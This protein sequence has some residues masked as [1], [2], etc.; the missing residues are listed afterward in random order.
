MAKV[1][2]LQIPRKT[3]YFGIIPEL[4]DVVGFGFYHSDSE[5]EYAYSFNLTYVTDKYNLTGITDLG[6]GQT[7]SLPYA[8]P[9]SP[10][11]TISIVE[12]TN[13]FYTI[14][15]SYDDSLSVTYCNGV[16][17]LP[18]PAI[19][20]AVDYDLSPAMTSVVTAI[21][22]NFAEL[23]SGKKNSLADVLN[24]LTTAISDVSSLESGVSNSAIHVAHLS[25]FLMS[26]KTFALSLSSASACSQS[27]GVSADFFDFGSLSLSGDFCKFLKGDIVFFG[28]Y[29]FWEVVDGISCLQSE[30]TYQPFYLLRQN[31]AL[32]GFPVEYRYNFVPQSALH[33]YVPD[34]TVTV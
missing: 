31:V 19:S 32:P 12:T 23:M 2:D 28:L 26:L 4:G 1:T 11:F 24:L 27:G 30:D 7:Q 3:T 16:V 20:P 15:L 10:V 5:S 21:G 14:R 18:P 13:A 22:Q 29:G 33:L 6:T 25:S 9:D 34:S 8:Y 17:L